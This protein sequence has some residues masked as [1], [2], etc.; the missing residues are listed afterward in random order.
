MI[1]KLNT[2]PVE[3]VKNI[4]AQDFIQHYVKPQKPV[5]IE[6]LIEDWP[7]KELWSLDYFKVI[8][9][10]LEVPLYDSRPVTSEFKYNEP[11]AKMKMSE[12]IDLLQS[13]P[14]DLRL[15]LFNLIK[16]RPKLQ[17]HIKM[18]DVGLK[19]F[20]DLPFLFIG[21]QNSKVFMHYDID[22]ANILHIHLKGEKQCLIFP[23]SE[24]KYLYKVPNSLVTN[25]DIDFTNPDFETYPALA[26]AKGYTTNLSS[27][28]TLYM[29]EGYWHH[30]HYITPGFS[31]SLRALA[32]KPK[33]LGKAVYNIIVMRS[34]E[35]LMR[36]W[37]GDKWLKA[38]QKASIINTHK[39]LNL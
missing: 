17:E 11:Q 8:A 16:E 19:L 12:Y 28:E 35:N 27:G 9:G 37:K 38:K 7:A 25:D 31:I 34:I 2:Q 3:R 1:Q 13:Q 39:S 26:Y 4:S 29:P 32:R 5:V 24:T 36:K 30:M 22:L 18:P 14:T 33:H 10:D 6:N 21:G 20:K 15:F 23:P